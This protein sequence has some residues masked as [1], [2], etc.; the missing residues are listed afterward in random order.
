MTPPLILPPPPRSLQEES[1]RRKNY[2]SSLYD[3]IWR[4]NREVSYL[5]EQQERIRKTD[6]SDLI[7]DS[8]GLRSDYDVSSQ[9][10]NTSRLS[11]RFCIAHEAC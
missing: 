8:A 7:R 11:A 5:T 9:G 4:C 1:L 2:L 3:Y 10:T 6:W